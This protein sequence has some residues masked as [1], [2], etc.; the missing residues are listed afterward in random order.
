MTDKTT[1]ATPLMAWWSIERLL[2]SPRSIA[3]GLLV[4]TP[5]VVC[6]AY[7]LFLR[8]G[9]DIDVSGF[10]LF[11][12]LS[13]TLGFQFVSPMLALFY[14]TGVVSDDVEQGT[15]R[16]LLTRPCSRASILLGKMLGSIAIQLAL[17]LPA[18]LACFYIAVAPEGWEALGARFPSLLKN[19]L[20]A[21]MGAA[22][23]NGLF[24]LLGCSVKRPLLFGLFFVFG[25]QAGATYVPGAARKLTVAHYQQSLLVQDSFDGTLV[26]L[27]SN[28]SGMVA[29]LAC[30]AAITLV[31]HALAVVIFQ[32]KE[33]L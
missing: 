6:L 31:S 16:Y 28:P 24:S 4:S 9:F 33:I 19:L 29:A 14:G 13:A 22:A 17:F 20:A 10:T 8:F 30:L 23:Y 27:V 25:W 11:S 12:V 15:M 21:T 26:N 7:R 18:L 32:R 5:V 2:L 3:M 1:N